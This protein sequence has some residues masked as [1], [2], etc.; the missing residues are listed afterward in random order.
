MQSL[1]EIGLSSVEGWDDSISDWLF[2]GLTD[3]SCGSCDIF[4]LVI[5]PDVDSQFPSEYRF[6]CIS[7]LTQKRFV[8]FPISQQSFL[9]E[10]FAFINEE[11]L[12]KYASVT[13]RTFHTL[14]LLL[15]GLSEKSIKSFSQATELR[16]PSSPSPKG[17][18][19]NEDAPIPQGYRSISWIRHYEAEAII[20]AYKSRSDFELKS[21]MGKSVFKCLF[22]LDDS[23]E[24]RKFKANVQAIRINNQNQRVIG[25]IRIEEAQAVVEA[26]ASKKEVEFMHL[27]FGN[28]GKVEY[29]PED[30]EVV[31]KYRSTTRLL[32]AD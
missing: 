19:G 2:I 20:H 23:D 22:F 30:S 12:D 26:H 24:R 29:F 14:K 21:D 15:G 5:A 4:S 17:L 7:C 11:G 31:R 32:R 3:F 1:E 18:R 9:S 6:L 16:A 10:K 8:D 28:G 27:K 25:W 13:L